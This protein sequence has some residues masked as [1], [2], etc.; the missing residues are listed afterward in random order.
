MSY[1]IRL[2]PVKMRAR[3]PKD[4]ILQR[5]DTDDPDEVAGAVE[6]MAYVMERDGKVP[7][8][9]DWEGI[10]SLCGQHKR[11]GRY[12]YMFRVTLFEVKGELGLHAGMGLLKAD[13]DG[14]DA[15]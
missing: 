7:Q 11:I 10:S 13:W 4:G 15:E 3:C 6:T 12:V 5:L 9:E 8:L 1:T 2:V 14:D